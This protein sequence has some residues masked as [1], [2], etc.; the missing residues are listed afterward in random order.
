MTAVA[1]STGALLT[2]WTL[3]PSVLLGTVAVTGAY[4]YA[5]GPLRRKYNLGPPPTRAQVYTFVASAVLLLVALVSPLDDIGDEY[6][7]SAHM[8][9]HLILATLWPPLPDEPALH[10]ASVRQ[11]ARGRSYLAGGPQRPP[12]SVASV[13]RLHNRER[14]LARCAKFSRST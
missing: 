6:L 1:P 3:E 12:M 11:S 4:F 10:S 2:H 7:F 9:Q 8:V 13:P 14:R 5:I